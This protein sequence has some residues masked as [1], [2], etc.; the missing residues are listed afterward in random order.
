MQSFLFPNKMVGRWIFLQILCQTSVF[1]R[2]RLF[3]AAYVYNIHCWQHI[4]CQFLSYLLC[5]RFELQWKFKG[6]GELFDAWDPETL[7]LCDVLEI[8]MYVIVLLFHELNIKVEASIKKRDCCMFNSFTSTLL[9]RPLPV[10]VGI[11]AILSAESTVTTWMCISR[12][13]AHYQHRMPDSSFFSMWKKRMVWKHRPS[14]IS[15]RSF[16]LPYIISICVF[17]LTP[18]YVVIWT[19]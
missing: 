7:L 11:P 16:S 17:L 4:T 2:P 3:S 5:L 8:F 13:L 18:N 19:C 6:M 1:R 10:W 9:N 15:N 14:M 12:H